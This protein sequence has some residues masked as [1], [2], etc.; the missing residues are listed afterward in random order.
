MLVK[1]LDSDTQQV[2][3]VAR[4]LDGFRMT[5]IPVRRVD[6]KDVKKKIMNLDELDVIPLS[7]NFFVML[8]KRGI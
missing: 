4:H 8:L 3:G 7:Q 5:N 1:V 2:W 6:A